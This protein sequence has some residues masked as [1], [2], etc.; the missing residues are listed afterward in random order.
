MSDCRPIQIKPQK[1]YEFI[2]DG[3]KIEQTCTGDFEI[4][5]FEINELLKK[6]RVKLVSDRIDSIGSTSQET[7]DTVQCDPV[8][9]KPEINCILS[10]KC[11]DPINI[12][13]LLEETKKHSSDPICSSVHLDESVE[14]RELGSSLAESV[15]ENLVSIDNKVKNYCT[16]LPIAQQKL[17]TE[18]IDSIIK[19]LSEGDFLN[20]CL[21]RA[22]KSGSK[23]FTQIE[24]VELSGKILKSILNSF[25]SDLKSC[26]N[27]K[28]PLFQNG[29]PNLDKYLCVKVQSVEKVDNLLCER[30][31]R[32]RFVISATENAQLAADKGREAAIA[33]TKSIAGE[34]PLIIPSSKTIV[35]PVP[36][37]RTLAEIDKMYIESGSQ[38]TPEF[39]A[40]A[41]QSFGQN[42]YEPLKAATGYVSSEISRQ[43]SSQSANSGS[44]RSTDFGRIGGGS[45]SR[46]TAS[47]TGGAKIQGLA[48]S[49]SGSGASALDA[50]LV[51]DSNGI[52]GEPVPGN[53]GGQVAVNKAKKP[54][55]RRPGGVT[56]PEDASLS[57]SKGSAG[58][59]SASLS[60]GSGGTKLKKLDS[61]E[62]QDERSNSFV[63]Q[64]TQI[65][66]PDELKKLLSESEFTVQ[67][68]AFLD[69]TG[70][71]GD[72]GPASNALITGPLAE[73]FDQLNVKVVDLKNKRSLYTPKKIDFI[74]QRTS[75]GYQLIKPIVRNKK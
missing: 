16:D 6:Y 3:I 57:G 4:C 49:K 48:K 38:I 71:P 68:T 17:V 55:V 53:N 9:N 2:C 30:R 44:K 50:S 10:E 45:D 39:A 60:G 1:H 21:G 33:D 75:K 26:G 12:K 14:I 36:V 28:P 34:T 27:K 23:P 32:D 58:I 22:Y 65:K 40:K 31:E 73:K 67:L 41:G 74:L 62:L 18:G 51:E 15:G 43:A 64:F 56:Q 63:S 13:T 19:S 37:G 35:D 46:T 29:A 47:T 54:I 52:S 66:S 70:R 24:K 20:Q 42:I 69:G 8:L 25:E 7:G 72:R 11:R 5:E 61:P 59:S